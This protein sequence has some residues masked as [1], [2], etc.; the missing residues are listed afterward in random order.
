MATVTPTAESIFMV[1][2]VPLKVKLVQAERMRKVKSFGM[3]LP[4]LMFLLITFVWPILSMLARSIDN[5]ELGLVLPETSVQLVAWDA[6]EL[7][8]PKELVRTLVAEVIT[9]NQDRTIGKAAKRLNYH[10]SGFRSLMKKTANKLAKAAE[11]EGLATMLDDPNLY[12]R[13]TKLDKRWKDREYWAIMKHAAP[14]KTAWYLLQS[15]DRDYDSD[16]NIVPVNEEVAIHVI[17]LWRTVKISAVVTL[18]CLMLGFPIAYLLASVPTR[19]GNILILLLLLPFW[20]SLLVRTTAWLVLLQGEGVVNDLAI[21]IGLWDE[22]LQLIRN[23][24]GTYIAMVHILLP[25]MTLP[26]FAVAKGIDPYHM[27]AALSLGANPV[28]AFVRVYLPQCIPGIGAGVLLVFILSLGFYITPA[29]VGGP[30]DQMLSYFIQ[31]HAN[32]TV[33]WGLASALSVLL[34]SV[35]IVF[36]ILYQRTIGMGSVRIR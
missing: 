15:V 14:P 32:S 13:M 23:R 29:L 10:Q 8:P 22:P 35:V 4:L 3:V 19:Q 26:L 7:P 2:G 1:D 12:E 34:M 31:F 28:R 27:K 24:L 20:T 33:N 6:K 5:P 18:L 11:T 25:F 17:I 16:K 30:A 21:T 9:A 36:I